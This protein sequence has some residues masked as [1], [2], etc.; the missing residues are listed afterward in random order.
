MSQECSKPSWEFVGICMRAGAVHSCS[1]DDLMDG[2]I[3]AWTQTN[4]SDQMGR[5]TLM[6]TVSGLVAWWSFLVAHPLSP[7]S[8]QRQEVKASAGKGK[9][10]LSF[11]RVAERRCYAA[12]GMMNMVAASLSRG[13]AIGGLCW[14]RLSLFC[15][16]VGAGRAPSA[17]GGGTGGGT[18]SAGSECRVQRPSNAS[19]CLS[20][21]S[22]SHH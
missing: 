20:Y 18:L 22:I 10:A 4:V 21:H 13:V 12:A 2:W 5:D 11:V 19:G 17:K 8:V 16:C 1:D 3:Q 6:M 7:S 14:A 15:F 9:K